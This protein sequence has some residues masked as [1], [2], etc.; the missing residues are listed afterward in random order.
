MNRLWLAGPA[1]LL[2]GGLLWAQEQVGR[3]PLGDEIDRAAARV[4]PPGQV[5]VK[6]EPAK[7][8]DRIEFEVRLSPTD[9]FADANA[10]GASLK[11]VRR[12]GTFHLTITGKPRP[13]YHTY[14]LT[15]RTSAQ[16]VSGLSTLKYKDSD[17]FR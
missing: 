3:S 13:K 10:V 11:E 12:G 1:V 15:R 14:P 7:I 8:L 2:G 9:P 17:A 16:D 6:A 5:Q 4:A